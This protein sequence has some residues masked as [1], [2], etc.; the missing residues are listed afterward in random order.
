MA[1][2][3]KKDPQQEQWEKEAAQ[4]GRPL[5]EIIAQARYGYMSVFIKDPEL[6]PLLQKAA[7]GGWTRETFQGELF[8]TNWYKKTSETQ[9][10]WSLLQ[11]SD[12]ASAAAKVE[13]KYRSLKLMVSQSGFRISDS[14]IRQVAL[15]TQALGIQDDVA[16]QALF[17]QA[18]YERAGG[19]HAHPGGQAGK[20]I[21]DM[22]AR[23]AAY[24]VG[25]GDEKAFGYA[26]RISQGEITAETVENDLRNL[27]KGK[28]SF[29]KDDIDR[30]NTVKDVLDP[31][32]QQYADLME[33]SATDV[34][35][36]EPGFRKFVQTSGE[37]GTRIMSLEESATAVRETKDWQ[38][39]R[40]A[41]KAASG[42]A[43]QVL[44]TFG[45]VSG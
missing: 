8:K 35:F 2:P 45:K 42:F 33:R 20:Q 3:A 26:Q 15:A 30:G 18:S 25:L 19:K 40:Q 4:T 10:N 28:W 5:W 14:A 7:E 34:D 17:A 9:R 44:R 31:Y 39:T 36:N 41:Q 22:K 43:E 38:G 11:A 1:E 29:L 23:A 6:G 21:A 27:A 13:G 24:G 16:Q 32:I 12:P 37:K